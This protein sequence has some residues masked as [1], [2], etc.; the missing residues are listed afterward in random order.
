MSINPRMCSHR[1][2]SKCIYHLRVS[3]DFI[4]S[5]LRAILLNTYTLNSQDIRVFIFI[6]S[7]DPFYSIRVSK[8]CLYSTIFVIFLRGHPHERNINPVSASS[9]WINLV[10]LKKHLSTKT[11]FPKNFQM[12]LVVTLHYTESPLLTLAHLHFTGWQI[13]EPAH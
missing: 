8:N 10:Q 4:G 12:Q 11:V 5:L 3:E 7:N 2:S 6:R 9:T 13:Y 1:K